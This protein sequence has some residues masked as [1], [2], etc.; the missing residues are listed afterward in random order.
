MSTA[1]TFANKDIL[2]SALVSPDGAEHYA[3]ST[4]S[5]FRGR[6]VTTVSAASGLVGSI[7]WR[8]KLFSINGLEVAPGGDSQHVRAFR[9]R[10]WNWGNRPYR[11]KFN[12]SEKELLATP[13]VGSDSDTVRF[14]PR[15]PHLV[16][17]NE[18]AV[19]YFPHQ[20]QDETERM[21]LL[22]AVLQ[23]EMHRQDMNEASV[24]AAASVG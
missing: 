16:H 18:R 17:D 2:K 3:T 15:H 11:L 6:K 8:G 9:E 24:A 22:L 12:F 10:E 7:D 5:G 14:T 20:L 1:F 19:L 4:T 23:T 13:T 21:F